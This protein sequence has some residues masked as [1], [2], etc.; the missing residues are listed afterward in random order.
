MA[1]HSFDEVLAALVRHMQHKTAPLVEATVTSQAADGSLEL[2]VP[3]ALGLGPGLQA[4]PLALAP[5]VSAVKV[6]PGARCL[7]EFIDDGP[8]FPPR[9]VVRQFLAATYIEVTLAATSKVAVQAPAVDVG[10]AGAAVKLAGGSRPVVRAGDTVAKGL[11]AGPNPVTG[12]ITPD[13]AGT[14]LA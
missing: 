14:V 5:G 8:G 11:V 6:A 3:E 10:N 12:T 9:P 7:L 1:G 13:P 2:E 4:V